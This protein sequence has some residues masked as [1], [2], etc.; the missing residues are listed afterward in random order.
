MLIKDPTLSRKSA[1]AIVESNSVDLLN[2]VGSS[3][4]TNM[5]QSEITALVKKQLNDMPSWTIENISLDGSGSNNVTYTY[6]NQL[7]Y[8]MVPDGDSV[9]AAQ[10]KIKEVMN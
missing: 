4:Q 7:L 1:G 9:Y 5:S 8:V 3:F 6:G 10:T 2:A